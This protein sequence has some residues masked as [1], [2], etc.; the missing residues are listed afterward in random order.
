MVKTP[1]YWV[2][3]LYKPWQGA[4]SL[5]ITLTSPWYHKDEVAVPAV[6]ASAVRDAAGQVHV[7]LVNLDPNRALPVSVALTGVQAG[8]ASGRIVTGAAMDTHNSFDAPDTVTPQPF[9]TA[10]VASG[11]LTLTLPAKSVVVLDLR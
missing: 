3:D 8:Q 7:A 9:T 10:Q 2:F 6:N 4:T 5:P 11:T 1:T